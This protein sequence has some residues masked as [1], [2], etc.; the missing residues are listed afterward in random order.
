MKA[1][2]P[3]LQMER[4]VPSWE[5]NS[6]YLGEAVT[7]TPGLGNTHPFLACVCG[8]LTALSTSPEIP[9]SVCLEE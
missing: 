9:Q 3:H 5:S 8:Y 6:S 1:P 2:G 7:H 4:P